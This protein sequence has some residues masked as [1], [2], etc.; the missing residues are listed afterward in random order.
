MWLGDLSAEISGALGEKWKITEIKITSSEFDGSEPVWEVGD[1]GKKDA[2]IVVWACIFMLQTWVH[3]VNRTRQ[4]N[5]TQRA[6]KEGKSVHA[7]SQF[8]PQLG[9]GGASLRKQG[10][11]LQS[12]FSFPSSFSQ[13][14]GVGRM[15]RWDWQHS[16]MR[17]RT[18]HHAPAKKCPTSEDTFRILLIA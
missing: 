15:L 5:C 9:S 3:S 2:R 6:V 12:A 10:S 13:L 4:V 18:S 8:T 17:L 11:E 7:E 16:T 1:G 14:F